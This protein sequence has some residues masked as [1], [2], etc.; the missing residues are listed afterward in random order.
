M[1]WI[2]SRLWGIVCGKA[3]PVLPEQGQKQP[4]LLKVHE[5]EL[6]DTVS[7]PR[8]VW[9]RQTSRAGFRAPAGCTQTGG[10][11]HWQGCGG[12]QALPAG[13]EAVPVPGLLPLRVPAPAGF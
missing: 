9:R 5:F 11:G 4:H 12:S 2:H 1:G 8:E 10:C 6:T 7:S 3:G 13:E